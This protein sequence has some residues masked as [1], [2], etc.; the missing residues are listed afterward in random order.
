MNLNERYSIKSGKLE[1]L[2]FPHL[3]GR[4]I[5]LRIGGLECLFSNEKD[6]HKTF[7][8]D[9]PNLREQKR[10]LGFPLFGGD[11]VW[12]APQE[13]WWETTP[14][15]ALDAGRYEVASYQADQS[16]HIISE[17]CEETGIRIERQISSLGAKQSIELIDSIENMSSFEIKRGLWNV[18]QFL[19]PVLVEA[20]ANKDAVR[21]Y[22]QEGDCNEFKDEIV[23][24]SNDNPT[25]SWIDCSAPRHFKFGFTP[26]VGIV[27]AIGV[28]GG[29]RILHTRDF[30]LDSQ[31]TYAHG[32]AIEVYNSPD[33]DYMELEVHAPL[34]TLFPGG[35][36]LLRQVWTFA[37]A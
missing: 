28:W 11:K 37:E 18:T 2:I 31:A 21:P 34:L 9:F 12:I 29:K 14:P 20:F 35:K 24:I 19:R 27:R 8:P 3:G 13:L 22:P 5:S 10:E 4:I 1:A 16:I 15:L 26:T 33:Q 17:V 23:G 30:A 6:Y 7:N 25:N 32:S 36:Q